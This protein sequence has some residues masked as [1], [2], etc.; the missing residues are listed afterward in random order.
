MTKPSSTCSKG[1]MQVA[2][3]PIR[4]RRAHCIMPMING[5]YYRAIKAVA[6]QEPFQTVVAVT[7]EQ[8]SGS[9]THGVRSPIPGAHLVTNMNPF[10]TFAKSNRARTLNQFSSDTSAARASTC[11]PRVQQSYALN[12]ESL[13]VTLERRGPKR[14]N[15]LQTRVQRSLS[16]SCVVWQLICS[17]TCVSCIS[18]ARL[19]VLLRRSRQSLCHLS[20]QSRQ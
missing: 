7:E 6:E 16:E 20:H 4:G 14:C 10:R 11:S 17:I 5:E 18:P 13:R 3:G 15:L 12:T 19:V 9:D 2:H 8:P 1:S